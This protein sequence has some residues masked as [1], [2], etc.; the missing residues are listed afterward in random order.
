M[1]ARLATLIAA[2][3]LISTGLTAQNRWAVKTNLL[4]DLTSSPNLALELSVARHWSIEVSGSINAW[5]IGHV[6]IQHAI[7]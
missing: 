2:F 7:V 5:P 3:L 1:K 4:H 6:N